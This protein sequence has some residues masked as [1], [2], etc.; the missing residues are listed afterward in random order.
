MLFG[1]HNNVSEFLEQLTSWQLLSTAF[2]IQVS[3][4]P[5]S[6]VNPDISICIKYTFCVFCYGSFELGNY[7]LTRNSSTSLLYDIELV[8]TIYFPRGSIKL[9]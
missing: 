3:S 1:Y 7:L 5:Y 4:I 8:K 9:A 2:F 6:H